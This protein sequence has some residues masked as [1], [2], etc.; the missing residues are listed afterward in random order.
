M[1]YSQKLRRIISIFS[2]YAFLSVLLCNL[3]FTILR[4]I[5]QS[6]ILPVSRLLMRSKDFCNISKKMLISISKKCFYV[7]T[8]LCALFFVKN[9]GDDWQTQNTAYS[10]IKNHQASYLI[11]SDTVIIAIFCSH[12]CQQKLTIA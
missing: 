4:T 3:I 12:F 8:R 1:S 7:L 6:K 2:H 11:C 9:P 10:F 5:V